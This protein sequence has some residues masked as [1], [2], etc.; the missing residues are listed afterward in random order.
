M[1]HGLCTLIIK[2]LD[3]RTSH[4]SGG[5]KR[6][7]SLGIALSGNSKFLILDEPSSGVD[8]KS[9][10]ELWKILEKYKFGRTMLVSTHYMDEAE[11]LSDKICIMAK[12]KL[13]YTG[14]CTDLKINRGRGY[15]LTIS[16]P[17]SC[18]KT[19]FA[20]IESFVHSRLNCKTSK[21]FDQE[22]EFLIP[23]SE[24]AKF[25]EFFQEL[26]M[27]KA[28]LNIES[29]GIK[30]WFESVF[31]KS[32]FSLTKILNQKSIIVDGYFQ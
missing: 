29:H 12:G 20:G 18:S 13:K 30:G 9:R 8:A 16:L 14:S 3:E 24:N 1:I 2:K 26:E 7:L 21:A 11:A 23:K 28:E 32:G 6:K 4:L 22:V 15:H 10:R 17:G 31:R 27:R 5:M 25:E 19:Q